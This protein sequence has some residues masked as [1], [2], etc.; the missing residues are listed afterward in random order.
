MIRKYARLANWAMPRFF[1]LCSDFALNYVQMAMHEV[2]VN[3][4]FMH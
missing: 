4:I 3:G 2:T 1:R